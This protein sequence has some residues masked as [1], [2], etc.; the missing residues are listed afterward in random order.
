MALI[1]M[2]KKWK[3]ALAVVISLCIGFIGSLFTSVGSWY[4]AL[5]KPSFNPPSYVF[6]PVWTLL[7]V[8]IGVALYFVWVARCRKKAALYVFAFQYF[9]NVMWSFF[10]FYMHN[11]LYAFIDI[12]LLLASIAVML[13]LFYRIDRRAGYLLVP[14]LLWVCFALVLNLSIVVLN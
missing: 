12:V 4:S 9:L 7:F 2:L 8:L 14:Y 5:V 10:F 11:P 3:L 1:S 13:V 6:G